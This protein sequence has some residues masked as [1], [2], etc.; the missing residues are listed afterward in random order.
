MTIGCWFLSSSAPAGAPDHGA[1]PSADQDKGGRSTPRRRGRG[2]SLGKSSG[3]THRSTS[4]SCPDNLETPRVAPGGQVKISSAYDKG[5]R[6]RARGGAEGGGSRGSALGRGQLRGMGPG[7]GPHFPAR[8]G[9]ALRAGSE[10]QPESMP[11]GR[12]GGRLCAA[13]DT[14][15][16]RQRGGLGSERSV[17]EGPGLDCG[18]R[19]PEVGPGLAPPARPRPRPL[20]PPTRASPRPSWGLA[21]R[22]RG[23]GSLEARPSLAQACGRVPDKNSQIPPGF[24]HRRHPGRGPCR[25][26][27]DRAPRPAWASPGYSDARKNL[28]WTRTGNVRRPARLV[29]KAAESSAALGSSTLLQ[30]GC[31]SSS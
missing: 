17:V 28:R 4:G 22:G 21:G 18:G 5:P 7:G 2:S 14:R 6:G 29:Q 20:G 16:R 24:L 25:G 19:R 31:M 13:Q 15:P 3:L 8:G 1:W 30:N 26:A 11:D 10:C 12:R 9:R 23:N 27:G